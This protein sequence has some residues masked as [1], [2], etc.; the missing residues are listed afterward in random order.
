MITIN[1]SLNTLESRDHYIIVPPEKK[2]YLSNNKNYR[3]VKD[4]FSYNSF[5]NKDYLNIKKLTQIIKK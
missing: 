4:N 5:N 3:S 2:I 1:D